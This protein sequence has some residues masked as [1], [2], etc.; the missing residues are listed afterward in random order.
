MTD[1]ASDF[2]DSIVEP[3]LAEYD[4]AEKALE[5][6]TRNQIV[7]L[8]LGAY[9]RIKADTLAQK[10][11]NGQIIPTITGTAHV[12]A[13]ATLLLDGRDPFCWGIR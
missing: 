4:E 3:A 11:P 9:Y 6:T 13:E 10:A 7:H 8:H 12:C 2:F 1:A 5:I